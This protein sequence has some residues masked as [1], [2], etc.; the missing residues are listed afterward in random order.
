MR[1]LRPSEQR[2]VI[3]PALSCA[4]RPFTINA[5]ADAKL[6]HYKPCGMATSEAYELAGLLAQISIYFADVSG[7]GGSASSTA[8]SLAACLD[9]PSHWPLL[10]I[11]KLRR[12]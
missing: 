7:Y 10:C 9:L 5:D 6:T 1:T 12:Y 2:W 4:Q 11:E 8:S 3:N